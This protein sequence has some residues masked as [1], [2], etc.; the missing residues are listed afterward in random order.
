MNAFPNREKRLFTFLNNVTRSVKW[1]WLPYQYT[2]LSQLKYWICGYT[3]LYIFVTHLVNGPDI[4]VLCRDAVVISC[5]IAKTLF[6]ALSFWNK[7]RNLEEIIVQIC[8]L[9]HCHQSSHWLCRLYDT[10]QNTMDVQLKKC[11]S[12]VW[13]YFENVGQNSS[14]LI[15]RIWSAN[16]NVQG[17]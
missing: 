4:I 13:S 1:F 12:I 10:R 2:D 17:Y 8:A 14:L 3:M 15:V 5:K 9:G 11:Q 16:C 6:C 7:T